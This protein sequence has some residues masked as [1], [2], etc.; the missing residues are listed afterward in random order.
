ML[1]SH[2]LYLHH[3]VRW[4]I[5]LLVCFP[6]EGFEAGVLIAI[7]G[8]DEYTP[9]SFFDIGLAFPTDN[10]VNHHS[11]VLYDIPMGRTIWESISAAK[12][13]EK[14]CPV[15]CTPSLVFMVVMKFLRL[16]LLFFQIRHLAHVAN[17]AIGTS[18]VVSTRGH[19]YAQPCLS[20]I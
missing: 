18:V 7:A 12:V 20:I 8:M 10:G 4:L 6:R 13:R 15:S 9:T 5:A 14:V 17:P 2:L 11:T 3:H 1:G 16:S 19:A